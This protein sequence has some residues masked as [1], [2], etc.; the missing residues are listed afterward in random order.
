VTQRFRPDRVRRVIGAD[1]ARDLTGMM[2]QVVDE[3]SGTAAR[4]QGVRVAGKTG[5]AERG[6]GINQAWFIAFAPADDPE[7]ALAVTVEQASGTGG[8]VAA[9]IARRVLE[10]ILDARGGGA[11]P[12]ASGGF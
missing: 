12:A 10:V 7:I 5:T 8:E 9:P 1:A 3:G 4:L 6:A 11:G 2:T